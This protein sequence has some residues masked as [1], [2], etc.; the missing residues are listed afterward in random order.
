MPGLWLIRA[1]VAAVWLYQGL[2]CKVLGRAPRH[3][4]VVRCAPFL[5]HRQARVCLLV[6]GWLECVL[7]GWV[8]AGWRPAGAALAQTALL[9]SMNAGGLVWAR[10]AIPDPAGMLI[11]NFAFLVLAWVAGGKVGPYVV[12][13]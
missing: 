8:L 6:L 2:W 10:R 11:H 3:G 4:D 1:G 5:S 12:H 9:A 13:G 7:A